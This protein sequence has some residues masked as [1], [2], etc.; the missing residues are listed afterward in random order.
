MVNLGDGAQSVT[1]QTTVSS[2]N[3][4]GTQALITSNTNINLS[5]N[6]TIKT[7]TSITVFY[8]D[9]L[10]KPIDGIVR[11]DTNLVASEQGTAVVTTA[12]LNGTNGNDVTKEQHIF[13]DPC[14]DKTIQEQQ[15]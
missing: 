15:I 13:F 2:H 12:T 4:N 5:C 14:I 1:R 3:G 9:A 11:K 6:A 7:T 10:S 8:N